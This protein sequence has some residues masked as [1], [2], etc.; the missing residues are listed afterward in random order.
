[1]NAWG[2]REIECKKLYH[3][4]KRTDLLFPPPKKKNILYLVYVLHVQMCFICPKI[5]IRELIKE[6]IKS[7][8]RQNNIYPKMSVSLYCMGRNCLQCLSRHSFLLIVPE[9]Y[10]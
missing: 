1:M 7:S 2:K 3:S 6:L 9:L 4:L 5:S 10:L 8:K